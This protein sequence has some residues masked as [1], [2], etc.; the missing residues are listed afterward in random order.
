MSPRAADGMVNP[1][2]DTSEGTPQMLIDHTDTIALS[3][4]RELQRE[5]AAERL[6]R[7]AAAGRG[8]ASRRDVPPPTGGRRTGW[9][10]RLFGGL[11]RV[12][13]LVRTDSQARA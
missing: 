6:G 5:A 9:A 12:T 2:T 3:R 8:R 10:A 4:I 13:G 7:I 11:A 1:D